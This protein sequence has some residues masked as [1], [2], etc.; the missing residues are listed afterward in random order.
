[1][2]DSCAKDE[3]KGVGAYF[4][5]HTIRMVTLGTLSTCQ[6]LP[7][8][9]LSKTATHD[10][11]ILEGERDRREGEQQSVCVTVKMSMSGSPTL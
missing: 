10:T 5:V 9:A 6:Q 11:H 3:A 1:M 2:F 8:H 7:L 4:A